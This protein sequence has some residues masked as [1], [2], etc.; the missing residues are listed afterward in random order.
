MNKLSIFAIVLA[1]MVACTSSK[2]PKSVRF[3]ADTIGFASKATQMD[4]VYARIF[5]FQGDSLNRKQALPGARLVICPHDD[6]AYVGWQYPAT[7][8]NITA[9]TV[10]ILGVAHKAKTFNIENKLVF[11]SFDC[12]HGPYGDVKVSPIRDELLRLMPADMVVVHDSLQ[13]AEHSVEPMIPFLQRSNPNIEIVSILVPYMPFARISELANSLAQ[14]IYSISSKKHLEWGKDF[15]FIISTDAVHYGDEGW[16][17]NNYAPF[18]A[19]SAGYA[20]AV[21]HEYQI[22]DSCL[23]GKATPERIE[24]FYRYTVSDADYREYRWTW[25]GRYCVPLGLATA[26]R[27]SNL[28]KGSSL[29]GKLV[30]YSTSIDHQPLLVEDLGM[31]RTAPASI[32]H[33]V[34]YA[35]LVYK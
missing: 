14:N 6:Y 13:L 28:S 35:S 12:W 5:R 23:A 24:R 31:G 7:L 3:F 10:I 26:I 18:G 17:G 11:D 29:E 34:G 22:V 4:S 19:D 30:S 8:R 1:S 25:C 16:G 2:S 32:R 15:A 9:K 27:L 20:K 21:E 33:W